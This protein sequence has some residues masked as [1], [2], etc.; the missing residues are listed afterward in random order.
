MPRLAQ[1]LKLKA[2]AAAANR[3]HVHGV[4]VGL[5][6]LLSKIKSGQLQL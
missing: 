6:V 5:L 4:I 2:A 1:A 3:F